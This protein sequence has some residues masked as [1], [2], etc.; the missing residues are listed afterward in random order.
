M[1]ILYL[2]NM[3][4]INSIERKIKRLSRNFIESPVHWRESARIDK[5][6]LS[7]KLKESY[8]KPY[9]K[10]AREV[11]D[12]YKEKKGISEIPFYSKFLMSKEKRKD[13]ELRLK[14]LDKEA[15]RRE[16]EYN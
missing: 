9:L 2:R 7:I 12:T 8:L 13:Y 10:W 1:E 6:I 4:E 11:Q 15:E 3:N 16:R 14:A 5:Q